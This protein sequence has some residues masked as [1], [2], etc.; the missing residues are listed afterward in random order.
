MM[1]LHLL[2]REQ[3]Y[4]GIA[5]HMMHFSV[6]EQF[7]TVD[8]GYNAELDYK[9]KFEGLRGT[10]KSGRDGSLPMW[11]MAMGWA[12]RRILRYRLGVLLTDF[13]V[14]VA[15][16][17][18]AES[19]EKGKADPRGQVNCQLDRSFSTIF[20][21]LCDLTL[22]L[23]VACTRGPG[24]TRTGLIREGVAFIFLSLISTTALF[25]LNLVRGLP[26]PFCRFLPSVSCVT[27]ALY[28]CFSFMV[29]NCACLLTD[30]EPTRGSL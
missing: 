2:G 26:L 1:G 27:I 30:R 18:D 25:H 21:D 3:Y 6:W 28:F 16:N 11:V 19:R 20:L 8:K 5:T 15:H 23:S 13:E 29:S 24:L 7:R 9:Q 12:G 17:F 14:L 22:L 10:G 4:H